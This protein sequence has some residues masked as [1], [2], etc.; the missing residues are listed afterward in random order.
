MAT[1]TNCQQMTKECVEVLRS[2]SN[3]N[4]CL[5]SLR[6][7]EKSTN[8]K[9]IKSYCHLNDLKNYHTMRNFTVDLMH[10]LLEGL[11]P[12]I[13]EKLFEYC[14]ENKIVKLQ[15]L[16]GLIECFDFG[17][18]SKQCIPSKITLDKKNLGQ[19]AS[20]LYCLFIHIPFILFKFKSELHDVWKPIQT[21]LEILQTVYSHKI[22]ENDLTRLDGLVH[23]HLSSFIN[24]FEENLKPKH[25][26]L[27]H[28]SKVIRSIG[29]VI[30]LWA[31]RMEAKHQF[32]KDIARR[33]KKSIKQI[34]SSMIYHIKIL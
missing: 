34:C 9:G 25:H 27:L 24:S 1:K 5:V 11:A 4:E 10:E 29:P 16:Q 12:L 14:V 2:V 33:T 7:D 26:F 28:Y 23:E 30:F 20:Q 18:L 19:N 6:A 15:Q 8:I 17:E 21:L 3:Y 31:M 22:N 32:F 13:L